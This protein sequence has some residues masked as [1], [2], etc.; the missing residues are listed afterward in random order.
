MF[1]AHNM[2]RYCLHYCPHTPVG[3]AAGG[4][5]PGT[6][7]TGEAAGDLGSAS[8]LSVGSVKTILYVNTTRW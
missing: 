5:G 7:E 3:A 8:S 4:E 1:S 2:F 6:G